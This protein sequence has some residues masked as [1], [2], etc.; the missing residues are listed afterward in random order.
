[1]GAGGAA[2]GVLN[3]LLEEQP[4]HIVIAN[5]TLDKAQLLTHI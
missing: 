4:E 5:R 1:M 3:P 2:Y